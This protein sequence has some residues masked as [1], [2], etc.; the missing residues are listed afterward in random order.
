MFASKRLY[1]LVRPESELSFL[2]VSVPAAAFWAGLVFALLGGVAFLLT[3]G[4]ETRVRWLDA[5]ARALIDLLIDTQTE[6]TKV[7]WP[8][9]EERVRS[10][11]AVL[12]SIVL[13]GAFL[14]GVDL[15]WSW[16]MTFLGVLPKAAA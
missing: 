11:F 1:A 9:T 2:G 3:F 15:L 13:L 7:S 4:V 8:S 12:V 14:L 6:L 16:L 5:K 10:T